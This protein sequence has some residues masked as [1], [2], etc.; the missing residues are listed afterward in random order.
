M[1]KIIAL[2]LIICLCTAS[3]LLFSSC[4]DK[5]E[6]KGTA[7]ETKELKEFADPAL[8]SKVLKY[9]TKENIEKILG[10]YPVETNTVGGPL[11]IYRFTDG[12]VAYFGYPDES[13][14]L[15]KSV[16]PK[17]IDDLDNRMTYDE[18]TEILGATG[19][20]T[21]NYYWGY[22]YCLTDGRILFISY[23]DDKTL[24][25]MSILSDVEE[26][27]VKMPSY[28]FKNMDDLKQHL[29]TIYYDEKT[30]AVPKL[31]SDDYELLDARD[32]KEY[33][34]Y[35][36]KSAKYGDDGPGFL[37]EVYKS[38]A[39]IFKYETVIAHQNVTEKDGFACDEN[40]GTFIF[41]NNGKAII[42]YCLLGCDENGNFTEKIDT[43][44]KLN[45]Y[46]VIEYF[47]VSGGA[48]ADQ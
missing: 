15:D 30:V 23:S 36:F 4:E 21:T 26:H 10:A 29:L 3:I 33:F 16:D 28:T 11:Y 47:D 7:T 18:V 22:K 38:D 37:I 40:R 6:Q 39:D 32:R 8:I 5:K 27:T 31:V 17:R 34:Y 12:Q 25:S 43:L 35:R 44:E 9:T 41:N 14:S 24:E 2:I 19:V 48:N 45:E 20:H 46:L 42:V 13:I 1:K